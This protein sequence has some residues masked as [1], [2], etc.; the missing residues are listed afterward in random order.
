MIARRFFARF[1]M[2]D[3]VLIALMAVLGIATKPVIVPLVRIITGPLLIPGGALAGGLYMMWLVMAAGLVG[4]P[5]AA[6]LT[7]I[8]QAIVVMATGTFGT[9]GIATLV[10]YTVPGIA[11]DV[12]FLFARRQKYNIGHYFLAG[13]AANISGTFL[14]MLVFFRL[15][16]IPLLLALSSG[17]LS[18]G[19]GGLIAF[20]IIKRF[21]KFKAGGLTGGG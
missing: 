8:V 2:F 1:Y 17:A 9:H 19:L 4:K 18:G 7:A 21:E 14:T 20:S 16:L 12:V 11:A 10:T 6:T 5:G 13:M 3:L 15:P